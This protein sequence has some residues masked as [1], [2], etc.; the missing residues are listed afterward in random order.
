MLI[1]FLYLRTAFGV[2]PSMS[3]MATGDKPLKRCCCIR[4]LYSV[5]RAGGIVRGGGGVLEIVIYQRKRRRVVTP[6]MD[7]LYVVLA[8]ILLIWVVF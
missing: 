7:Q 5:E 6:R 3:A 1:R 2:Y 4:S 8:S